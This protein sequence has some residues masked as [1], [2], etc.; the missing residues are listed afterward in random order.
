MTASSRHYLNSV[1]LSATTTSLGTLLQR[2]TIFSVKKLFLM[3]NLNFPWCSFLPSPHVL[4]LVTRQTRA[5]PPFPLSPWE[6]HRLHWVLHSAFSKLNKTSDSCSLNLGNTSN[7]GEPS[8][9]SV[10]A[11]TSRGLYLLYMGWVETKC[12]FMISIACGLSEQEA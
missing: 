12:C 2:P 3:F 9:S 5:A 10:F 1:R 6:N 8:S 4:S 7:L 11:L